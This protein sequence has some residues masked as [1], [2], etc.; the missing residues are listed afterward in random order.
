MTVFFAQ[1]PSPK[2]PQPN[3]ETAYQFGDV[4]FVFRYNDL[5][6]QNPDSSYAFAEQTLAHFDP[7]KDYVADCGG[8][9]MSMGIIAHILARFPV[10]MFLRWNRHKGGF[11]EVSR[12]GR[13]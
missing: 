5:V 8:D 7:E 1:E 6:S 13:A 9:K 3:L 12:I 2:K 4:R 10:V 11:Y